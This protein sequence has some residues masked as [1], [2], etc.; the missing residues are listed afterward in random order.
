MN[1]NITGIISVMENLGEWVDI[2]VL[3]TNAED[4]KDAICS[5]SIEDLTV[6]DYTVKYIM[7]KTGKEIKVNGF[8][9]VNDDI[10]LNIILINKNDNVQETIQYIENFIQYISNIQPN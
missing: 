4:H 2:G 6:N 8:I 9:F 5:N 10:V 1:D 3:N 7:Y